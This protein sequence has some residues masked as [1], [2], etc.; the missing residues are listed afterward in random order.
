VFICT[1]GSGDVHVD[2]IKRE[3][4]YAVL[5]PIGYSEDGQYNYFVQTAF[6]ELPGGELEYYFNV[7][8]VDGVNNNEYFYTSGWDT[9]ILIQGDDRLKVLSAICAATRHLIMAVKPQQCMRC[10]NDAHQPDK[11]LEKHYLISKIFEEAGYEVV[12]ADPFH[13]RRIWWMIRGTT[14]S[15]DSL[16]SEA[17][18]ATE[19][20]DVEQRQAD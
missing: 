15:A 19:A 5:V 11:A 14:E 4:G 10:T 13:G 2:Y 3:F 18:P 12:T 9:R 6:S 7:I 1:V 8:E 20:T 16:C 17:D